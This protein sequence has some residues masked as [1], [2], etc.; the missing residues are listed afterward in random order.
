MLLNLKQKTT[1]YAI[2]T[3]DFIKKY[4]LTNYKGYVKVN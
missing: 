4:N 2:F 3:Y 1:I